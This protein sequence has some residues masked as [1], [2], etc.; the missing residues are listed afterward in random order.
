MFREQWAGRATTADTVV[1]CVGHHWSAALEKYE[2]EG[3]ARVFAFFSM[4]LNLTLAWPPGAQT[5]AA[6]AAPG[7]RAWRG[8][9]HS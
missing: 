9:V 6:L 7:P 2:P 3:R 5:A 1:L 4:H 8:A